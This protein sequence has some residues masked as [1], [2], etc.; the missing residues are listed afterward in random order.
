MITPPRTI[1]FDFDGTLAPNLD[2]PDMRRQV[3]ELTR[4]HGV[5]DDVWRDHYI[6]EII[7]SARD[8]M[9]RQGMAAAAHYYASAHQLIT[10]IE[11]RAAESTRVFDWAP[12]ILARLRSMGVSVTIVTRNCEAAVRLTFPQ[13][14]GWTDGLF[15]RDNSRFL[16]PDP[17]HFI[18]AMA[19]TGA[20]ANSTWIVS[21]GAM[22]MR[23]GRT[24]GLHC[25]GVL[26]GSNNHDQ[27]IGSG[28]HD[29]IAD[30]SGLLQLPA[31]AAFA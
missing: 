23:T 6:V 30:A 1:L 31:F 17:R 11:M 2:L 4:N 24:L 29:V 25:I 21:D 20:A 19:H 28:A 5:P 7:S 16:K 27:L 22:D 15:A 26:S 8:W 3:I 18:E 14:E 12:S 10:N 13:V 9:L